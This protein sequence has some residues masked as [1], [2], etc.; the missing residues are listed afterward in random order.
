MKQLRH[1]TIIAW[2]CMAVGALAASFS[3]ISAAHAESSTASAESTRDS[4]PGRPEGTARE[5]TISA[6]QFAFSPVQIQVQKD[7]LVKITLNA[8]D[9]AHSFTIDQYRIAKRAA[10]GQSVTFEFRADQV[11]THR[12]YC[13]LSQDDRCR[14]MEGIL[15]VR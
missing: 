11:G 5:F 6:D 4:L 2:A 10:A 13:N 14:K 1:K 3:A 8:R 15:I 9:I 7:D 12:F